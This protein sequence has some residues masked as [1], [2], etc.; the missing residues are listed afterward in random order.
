MTTTVRS[1]AVRLTMENAAYIRG[2]NQAAGVTEQATGRMKRAVAGAAASTSRDW[3]TMGKYGRRAAIGAAA[4]LGLMVKTTAD[5]T[6]EMALVRT[7]S[8]ANTTEM[9]KLNRAALTMGRNIGYSAKEVAQGEEEMIKAGVSVKDILG[10]GLKGALELAAAGQTDVATATTIAASSLT[11]F[12]LQGKDIPHLA[13]LLSAG[14]D[15]ALGSVEDLGQGLEQSGTTAH[16]MGL[17]VEQTVGTLAAFAQA[18][19]IGE[20]GGTTFKQMLLQLAAPTKQAQQLMDAYGISLYKSNGQIKSMPELA[21]NLK[22]SLSGLTPAQRNAALGVIFGSRAIQGANILMADG[23]AEI[24]KWIR[25]VDDQGFAAHQASGKLDS[26]S[27]DYKKL[28]STLNTTL[29]QAGSPSQQALRDIVQ[30]ADHLVQDFSKLPDEVQAGIVK[31]IALTG[32]IGGTMWAIS[33]A[34]NVAKD[35]G[36]LSGRAGVA[37]G[38][39]RA[40]SLGSPVPVFV[41]NLGAGGLGG[42]GGPTILGGGSGAAGKVKGF[43][44]PRGTGLVMTAAGLTLMATGVTSKTH[45]GSTVGGALV[46][47]QLFGVPGALIGGG[48]GAVSDVYN[49]GNP[50]KDALER[51]KKALATGDIKE[52][53]AALADLRKEAEKLATGGWGQNFARGITEITGRRREIEETG[54]ALQEALDPKLRKQRKDDL[55]YLL[56]G[57]TRGSLHRPKIPAPEKDPL[58]TLLNPSR[59]GTKKPKELTSEEVL[60]NFYGINPKKLKPVPLMDKI[61][62][63]GDIWPNG[64]PGKKG[65]G[66]NPVV[67]FYADLGLDTSGFDKKAGGARRTAAQLDAMKINPSVKVNTAAAMAE[68]GKFGSYLTSLTKPRSVNVSVHVHKGSIG[69]GGSGDLAGLL[70]PGSADGGTIMGPRFPYG[71]KVLTP[72]APGEEVISN[73]RGQADK[74]RPFLKAI[75]R[76]LADGGTVGDIGKGAVYYATSVFARMPRT[77]IVVKFPPPSALAAAMAAADHVAAQ[78]AKVSYAAKDIRQQ[79]LDDLHTQQEIRD[80]QKSLHARNKKHRLEL[81][82]LDRKVAMAELADAKANLAE[83]RN[84]KRADLAEAR[85]AEIEALHQRR[86]DQ[87]DTFSSSADI[88]ARG[89]SPGSVIASVDRMVTDISQYGQVMTQLKAAK[90]SPALLQQLVNR[91]NTGDFRSAIRLGKA[92]LSQPG[93]LGRL[94][95]SLASLGAVSSSVATMV[96]DPRFLSAGAWNPGAAKVVQVNIGADPS[97]W[98]IEVKRVVSMEVA[99]Q[100]GGAIR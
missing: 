80:L 5:F 88:F 20:R 46:G 47:G 8:H 1:A 31:V 75:N 65:K 21:D 57:G 13:D 72:T 94:N 77:G 37:G 58:D 61:L 73:R 32:A 98:L 38:L 12:K 85:K 14:A 40:A 89:T 78:A 71:D 41:T 45:T 10:G 33:K 53:R 66:K 95:A 64:V 42:K 22:R 25:K 49:S 67:Q 97:A 63:M 27:G 100:I 91:A 55:L 4:G 52:Q 62:D 16:Q 70:N 93:T 9:D 84:Q 15:K 11:Q 60:A 39:G 36:Y 82:G 2:A 6:S 59:K 81:R 99:A 90:A 43:A 28:K 18:G 92:L 96:T 56:S 86:Q 7:L 48:L 19:L 50:A 83:I 3:D 26:L 79:G 87:I 23:R 76:G 17:S 30:T 54:K 35:F 24:A 69:A 68:L 51:A 44:L 74:W 29:I 34:R